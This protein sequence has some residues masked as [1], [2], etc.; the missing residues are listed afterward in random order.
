MIS[1]FLSCS[2]A[3]LFLNVAI[4][5]TYF[6]SAFFNEV[7]DKSKVNDTF[8]EY[9]AKEMKLDSTLTQIDN[10]TD[11]KTV[12]ELKK[13]INEI[14]ITAINSLENDWIKKEIPNISKGYFAYF[15]GDKKDLYPIDFKT[16]KNIFKEMI[17]KITEK[18]ISYKD[19]TNRLDTYIEK[20]NKSVMNESKSGISRAKTIDLL[21]NDSLAKD[22]NMNRDEVS[23]IIDKVNTIQSR[24]LPKEEIYK[25]FASIVFVENKTFDTMKDSLDFNAIFDSKFGANQNPFRAV[26]SFIVTLKNQL[27]WFPFLTVSMMLLLIWAITFRLYRFLK[28]VG[29]NLIS[30]GF[31]LILINPFVVLAFQEAFKAE[32]KDNDRLLRAVSEFITKPFSVSFILALISLLV[33]VFLIIFSVIKNKKHIPISRISP[34][35]TKIIRIVLSITLIVLLPLSVFINTLLI[36]KSADKMSGVLKNF[37]EKGGINIEKILKED[38][39]WDF[40]AK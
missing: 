10:S 35:K 37:E 13:S 8:N 21:M 27:I 39:G 12:M 30:A 31:I 18:T 19:F 7:Y 22:F 2:I 17:A 36:V 23:L 34:E 15:L 4:R 5:S 26:K 24:N 11:S 33:G 32:I 29:I 40:P 20:V 38:I 6:S 28:W 14:G 9:I 3:V 25:E 1:I 16:P